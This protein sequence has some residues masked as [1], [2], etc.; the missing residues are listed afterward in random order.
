MT[1]YKLETRNVP[2]GRFVREQDPANKIVRV[3]R[4]SPEDLILQIWKGR[5]HLL[6]ALDA[7]EA[8]FIAEALLATANELVARS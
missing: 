6:V 2:R 7:S 4:N 8:R 5:S 1:G 3:Y